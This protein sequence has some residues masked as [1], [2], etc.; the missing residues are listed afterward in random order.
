MFAMT[1][2]EVWIWVFVGLALFGWL[3]TKFLKGF[4][5]GL[6]ISSKLFR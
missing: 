3:M 1:G 2:T 5:Q 4:A 6:A